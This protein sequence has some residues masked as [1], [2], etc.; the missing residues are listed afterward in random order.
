MRSAGGSSGGAAA[1]VAAGLVPIAHASDGAGSIRVPAAHCGV[2]GF[3]P[4]RMR[5]PL[6]PRIAES[7]AG[8]GTPHAITRS[9]RDSAALL[10]ATCGADIGDPYAVEAPRRPFLEETKRDPPP[11][12]IGLVTSP[13][14]DVDVDPHC[15]AAVVHAATLCGDL[16]HHVEEAVTGHHGEELKKAWRVIAGAGCAASVGPV[17]AGM[18][19]A[20]AA[21]LIEPVNLEWIEEGRSWSASDY[22]S[23]VSVLHRTGRTIG[24]FFKRFDILLSPVTAEIAPPLGAL[25]GRG[26]AL[27]DFYNRFWAHAPFTPLFNATGFPAMSVPL[28]WT[29]PSAEAPRGVPVGVQFG[30]GPGKDGA[31]F[32]L[33]A[34]LERAQPWS[35]RRPS[36][37]WSRCLS[38]GEKW[39]NR[40]RPHA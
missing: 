27:A 6:G 9:V 16:G 7:N 14:I 20:E 2:F 25:A 40:T 22:L 10:D 17:I 4:S 21:A 5:N 37:A 26:A 13:G 18:S 23:A 31:L 28:Y 19:P 11:L 35:G 29:V 8:M 39:N 33:P 1:A 3:K 34:Q 12:R 15:L 24:G 32:G 30:A 36:A 38:K